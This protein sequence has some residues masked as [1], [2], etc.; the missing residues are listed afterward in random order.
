MTT[1]LLLLALLL[2]A[3]VEPAAVPAQLQLSRAMVQPARFC[4]AR[5]TA[6][7]LA[8]SKAEV[9]S[10]SNKIYSNS[11]MHSSG[12]PCTGQHSNKRQRA[13]SVERTTA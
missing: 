3:S 8:E 2:M 13:T 9:A 7:S 5:L 1:V 6:A 12:Q 11:H 4:S 10:S